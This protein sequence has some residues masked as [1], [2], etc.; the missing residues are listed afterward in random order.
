MG[1]ILHNGIV[2]PFFM[3]FSSRRQS[4]I[5]LLL[6]LASKNPTTVVLA[7]KD[8]DALWGDHQHVNLSSFTVT[9]GN[10]DIEQKSGALL[11][12]MPQILVCKILSIPALIE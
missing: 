11:F 8:K 12:I 1:I 5:P 6:M 9:L 2:K 4:L 10:V 3:T 7:F